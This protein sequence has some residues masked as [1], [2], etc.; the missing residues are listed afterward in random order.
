MR[1][2]EDIQRRL[3]SLV[4]NPSSLVRRM[5]VKT[6]L[7][8]LRSVALRFFTGRKGDKKQSGKVLEKPKAAE[9]LRKTPWK[10]VGAL[11]V[12]EGREGLVFER[13]DVGRLL[14]ERGNTL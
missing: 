11:E 10:I 12:G 13:G 4:A 14:Y 9:K 5:I 7:H 6:P 1:R 3:A 2:S 8:L